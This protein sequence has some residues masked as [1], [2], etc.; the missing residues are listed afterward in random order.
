MKRK[1]FIV[2]NANSGKGNS[3]SIVERLKERYRQEGIDFSIVETKAS[4]WNNIDAALDSDT[5]D[6]VAIGG[7]GT[8]NAVVNAMRN[9]RAVLNIIPAGSGND[10]V[11]NVDIGR[12][13]NEN[14]ETVISGI[15]Q[16]V[17]IGDCNGR[18]FINGVGLGF[19]GQIVADMINKK[20]WLQGHVKYYYHVLKIL[21]TY[22]VIPLE[23]S[24]SGDT[25]HSDVLLMTIAKGTTFGGGFKLTPN[26]D[27]ADGF[28]QVCTISHIAPLSRFLNI[29][30]LSNGSHGDLDAVSFEKTEKLEIS[31]NDSIVGHIDGEYL[32]HPP[33][34]IRVIPKALKLRVRK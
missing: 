13:L 18:L 33:F 7:D 20:T 31:P 26:A 22:Q 8:L 2:F 28:L 15:E 29:Y 19:D 4:S 30:K 6:I 27:L 24:I 34:K 11:K 5:T 21:A 32:G 12:G 23:Y 25:M 14:I 1:A 17:D 3:L 16:E 9:H 10:Y